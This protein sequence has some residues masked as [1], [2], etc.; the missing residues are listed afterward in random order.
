MSINLL[1]TTLARGGEHLGDLIWWALADARIDRAQLEQLWST[2]GLPKELLVEQPSAEKAFKC[3][4]RE[5]ATGAADRL[6][7]LGKHGEDEIVFAVVREHRAPDGSLTYSQE[8]RVVLDRA[9]ERVSLDDPTH[10]L[11]QKIA[12]GFTELRHTHTADDVRRSMLRVLEQSAAVTLRDHGGVYWVPSPGAKVVRQLQTAIEQIGQSTVQLLPVH[13][14]AD[15]ERTLGAA[16]KGAIEQELTAL[17]TEMTAFLASPP[18]R[19][20]TLARRFEVYESLRARAALYRQVLQVEV[21][22][23][24]AGLTQL[25]QSLEGLLAQKAA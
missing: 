22:D 25:T 6:V 15:A 9:T 10:E 1:K 14:S 11:G 4:A 20:S 3:A 5:A 24:E 13:R 16:A 12:A 19:A 7:R 21:E 2:A 8:T 23:L 18:E 17:R